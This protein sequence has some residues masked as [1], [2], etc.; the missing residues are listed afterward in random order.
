MTPLLVANSRRE[1][2]I[3]AAPVDGD[4]GIS[5]PLDRD[6]DACGEDGGA[7]EG[8]RVS[9]VGAGGDGRLSQEVDEDFGG[10]LIGLVGNC[11][12]FA[13]GVLL[14]GVGLIRHP[15]TDLRWEWRRE[16][17][18]R[19]PKLPAAGDHGA[20]RG[21]RGLDRVWGSHG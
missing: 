14:L 17:E 15:A 7:E 1:F 2:F 3:P 6:H 19:S 16:L 5:L 18:A 4:P 9:G 8:H 21:W 11:D 13:A 10:E 20:H 12:P